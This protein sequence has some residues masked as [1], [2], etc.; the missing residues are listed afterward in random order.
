MLLLLLLLLLVVVLLL[1]LLPLVLVLPPLVVLLL[2]LLLLLLLPL[3]LPLPLL[4]L[5]LLLLLVVMVLLPTPVS[6][7]IFPFLTQERERVD[8]ESMLSRVPAFQVPAVNVGDVSQLSPRLT[9]PRANLF[10]NMCKQVMEPCV[11]SSGTKRV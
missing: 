7:T 6:H 1:L 4:L 3:P 11:C 8:A 10:A 2:L 5:L 9:S